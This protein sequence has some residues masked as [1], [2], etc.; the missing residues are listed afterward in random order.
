[1]KG[2]DKVRRAKLCHGGPGEEALEL[3]LFVI[4]EE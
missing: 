2:K 3:R 1:M 4:L